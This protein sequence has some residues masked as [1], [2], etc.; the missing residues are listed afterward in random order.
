MV[1][2]TY[3]HYYFFL[4]LGFR[5]TATDGSDFPW[6]GKRPRF[7]V[8]GAKWKAQISGVRFYTYIQEDF[9]FERWKE[10][11]KSGHTF[12]SSGPI[13]N[14]KVNGKIPGDNLQISQ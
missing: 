12:V 10:N 4:D 9:S 6:C 5:L 3:H 13:I 2:S 11:F 14:L 8:E 1:A 7:G